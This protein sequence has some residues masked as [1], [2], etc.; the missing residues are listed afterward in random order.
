M[1]AVPMGAEAAAAAERAATDDLLSVENLTVSFDTGRGRLRVVEDVSFTVGRGERVAIVGESGSGKSVTAMA[2]MRL[3]PPATSH[4]ESGRVRFDG[5]DLLDL[6]ARQMRDVRGK[7]IAMI[8]QDALTSLNPL[9]TIGGQVAEPLVRHFGLSRQDATRRAAELLDM[10]RIPGGAGALKKYPHEFSGGM[11][12]RVMIAT[13]LGCRPD[14]LIAD[15]P[16]T[17]LDVTVQAE[18]L[19]L[20]RELSE[21]T[22]VSVLI[23]THDLGVVSE[24]ADRVAVMYAGRVAEVAPVRT[25]FARPSHPYTADLLGSMPSVD[26]P[27]G[28]RLTAIRGQ[29]PTPE[30]RGEGCHYAPRC[31]LAQDRCAT[32][33]PPL[34]AHEGASSPAACW[35]SDRVDAPT[36]G[37]RRAAR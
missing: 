20:M 34:V 4:I 14:L 17:A 18:M 26:L 5:T 37:G 11:R 9:M 10:V 8:F 31:A 21:E 30:A 32:D 3:L 35:Y 1:T 33:Q 23:I 22:G 16:T 15:E 19:R 25:A 7:R 2:I 6:G 13:A 36:E 29:L 28:T 12:Q 27:K 24:F